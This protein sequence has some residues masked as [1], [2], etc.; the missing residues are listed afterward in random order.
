MSKIPTTKDTLAAPVNNKRIVM[1]EGT[2][3][4]GRMVMSEA[5]K[6]ISP[7]TKN[8]E[9]NIFVSRSGRDGVPVRVQWV[10]EDDVGRAIMRGWNMIKIEEVQALTGRDQYEANED[11]K[12]FGRPGFASEKNGY[13]FYKGQFGMFITEAQYQE[14]YEEERKIIRADRK[15]EDQQIDFID[16][17]GK[18]TGAGVQTLEH[19]EQILEIDPS[20]DVL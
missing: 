9:W 2:G 15:K 6:N 4:P 7:H 8:S 17:S 1:T 13:L 18:K 12:W 11:G 5:F 20:A 14:N 19:G 16:H 3:T 10:L